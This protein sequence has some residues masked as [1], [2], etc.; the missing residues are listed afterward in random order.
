MN[1]DDCQRSYD[2]ILILHDG[3]YSV[4]NQLPVSDLAISDV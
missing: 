1:S 3:G 2:V 4:V